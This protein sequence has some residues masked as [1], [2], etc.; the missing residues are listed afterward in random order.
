MATPPNLAMALVR[1]MRITA[2]LADF[3]TGNE[4]GPW[5]RI[6]AKGDSVHIIR[7]D[8]KV[9]D[10]TPSPVVALS[11]R[12]LIA[13]AR[14]ADLGPGKA[15]ELAKAGRVRADAPATSRKAAALAAG[16]LQAKHQLVIDMLSRAHAGLTDR[17]ID[18]AAKVDSTLR[19]RR[20]ELTDAGYV[21]D[22]GRVRDVG[23]RSAIVWG[24]T[25]KAATFGQQH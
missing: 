16:T 10:G 1:L 20:I 7:I 12:E 18:Q 24:L 17:E 11:F 22:T 6:E 8:G 2:G 4:L 15:R 5:L 19:P 25:A 3:P 23:G 13:L 9:G 14:R 21:S